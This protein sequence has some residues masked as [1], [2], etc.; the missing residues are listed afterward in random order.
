LE[1]TKQNNK[2][3]NYRLINEHDGNDT[4]DFQVAEGEDPCSAALEMLGWSLVVATDV[5]DENE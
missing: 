1:S 3:T 5:K 2:M 4:I